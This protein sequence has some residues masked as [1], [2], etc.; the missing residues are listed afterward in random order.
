MVELGLGLKNLR[1]YLLVKGTSDGSWRE[2][3][4]GV[5]GSEYGASASAS[6]PAATLLPILV[7]DSG[8]SG[9]CFGGYKNGVLVDDLS[10][11]EGL[12][13]LLSLMVF[14]LVGDLLVYL[15]FVFLQPIFLLLQLL[16]AL[17]V[18]CSR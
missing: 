15:S 12:F 1:F 10:R 11:F 13:L 6:A 18:G 7:D 3:F 17:V 4:R 2:G 9:L 16:F 5:I 8:R 14:A